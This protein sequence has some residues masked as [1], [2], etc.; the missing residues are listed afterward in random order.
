MAAAKPTN[1]LDLDTI[2]R[3]D[4]FEPFKVNFGGREYI[5]VDPKERDYKDNLTYLRLIQNGMSYRAVESIITPEDRDEFFD[6]RL[7]GWKLELLTKRYNEHF[8]IDTPEKASASS[9]S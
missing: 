3:E 4:V 6:N 1:T 7:P 5:L 8:G 9:T 2:E